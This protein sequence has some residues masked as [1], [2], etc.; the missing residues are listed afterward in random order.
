MPISGGFAL[1]LFSLGGF[2]GETDKSGLLVHYS[3]N[4][5][6]RVHVGMHAHNFNWIEM[7]RSIDCQ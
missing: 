5:F 1:A 3:R 6:M 2:F 7:L 4:I